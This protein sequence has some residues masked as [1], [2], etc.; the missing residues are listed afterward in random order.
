VNG[1][2][3]GFTFTYAGLVLGK[4]PGLRIDQAGIAVVGAAILLAGGALSAR[5]A[6]AAI[7]HETL[8]LLFAMMVVVAYLRLGSF[9][10]LGQGFASS[11]V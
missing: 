2:V 1:Y 10:E 4:V 3:I 11:T 6:V 7:D 5:E 8:V 9:F